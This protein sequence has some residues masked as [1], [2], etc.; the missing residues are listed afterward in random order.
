MRQF[1]LR[2]TGMHCAG[3]AQ[4]VEGSLRGATGV[5]DARVDVVRGSARVTVDADNAAAAERLVSALQATGYEAELIVDD[6]PLDRLAAEADRGAGLGRQRRSVIAAVLLAAGV[7]L[8]E[9]AVPVVWGHGGS[10]HLGGRAWPAMTVGW[11]VQLVLVLMIAGGPAGSGI[12]R[13]GPRAIRHL[14]PDMD[15]LVSMGVV[16][17][18]VSSVYGVFAASDH[19]FVH[20]HAAA[21]ILALVALGRYLESQAKGRASA[22]M[23]AL[24]RRAPKEA[25]VR[26]NGQLV[27]LP[28][29]EIVV[30][31]KISIPAD[32][33]IPTDG[34]V[35][36][37]AAA[38]D[39]SLMTGEA[40]PVRR[41]AG[42]R[43]LGG[44][45]VVDG[46]LVIRA[47]AVGSRSA[48]GRI[49]QLVADAQASKAPMQRLADRVAGVFAL[50]VIAAAVV[51]FAAWLTVGGIA[52]MSSAT[53]SAVAVLV[54]ACPCALGLATP[55][56]VTVACGLAALRGILVRDAGML[57]AM[58]RVDTVVWDKT[59]TLTTG[60]SVVRR[61]VT[62]G[63]WNERSVLSHAASVEQFSKHP[64]AGAIVAYA[65]QGGGDVREAGDF[66]SHPGRGVTGR[67]DGKTVAV[68]SVGLLKTFGCDVSELEAMARASSAGAAGAAE[69]VVAVAVGGVVVG[70]FVLSDA[71]RPAA[72][73]AIRRLEALGVEGEVLSGD[74]EQSV[75]SVAEGLGVTRWA[76]G[77][78][79]E[80]KTGRIEELRRSGRRVAMV[81][82]GVNDAAALAAADVGVAFATG[83]DVAVE[84]AGINLVGSAPPLVADAVEL[85]RASVR[86]IRQNLFWAFF[87]NVLMIPLAAAG[88]LPPAVAAAAMM[89]S[90]LTV[91]WN[92]LRL[93]RVLGWR[94]HEAEYRGS[95][96]QVPA[97]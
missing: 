46:M 26:R 87:Y 58:G 4:R 12:L 79:P 22:A 54:V 39:E 44:T 56:V 37:G 74:Q 23:T 7:F 94:S 80:G 73:E 16:T 5:V 55:T 81:G 32:S 52:A 34:E 3:C 42:G 6:A 61:V 27:T 21:M 50:I 19:E 85:A 35:I 33:L 17:A 15:L 8:V 30:G 66:A 18:L 53:R 67:L 13:G 64:L 29:E 10:L 36:E 97:R 77:V 91:V 89:V 20:L 60:S 24:A 63:G 92:A 11:T 88:R 86:V 70:A 72:G 83:A 45:G 71:I 78:S 68:G 90:S 65:R 25:L 62:F 51:T 76:G 31:D 82:D 47:T 48:L 43:V 57:E 41:Q 28:V 93:P 2:V 84:S 14:A 38:V 9:Y 96:S 49:I 95:G 59:G 75:R 69:A 1:R 40:M